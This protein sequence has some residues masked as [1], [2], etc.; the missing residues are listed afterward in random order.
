VRIHGEHLK[1]GA[2]LSEAGKNG[3][4]GTDADEGDDCPMFP[5][6]ELLDLKDVGVGRY[7]GEADVAAATCA[8]EAVAANPSP[9]DDPAAM[10]TA[11][12]STGELAKAAISLTDTE[13]TTAFVPSAEGS[14]FKLDGE[15]KW[16]QVFLSSVSQGLCHA[17]T[18]LSLNRSWCPSGTRQ[19]WNLL[20]VI[21][22]SSN[23]C[24]SSLVR[25]GANNDSSG[26]ASHS[27]SCSIYLPYKRWSLRSPDAHHGAP[28]PPCAK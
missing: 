8:D 27:I 26:C 12:V 9:A 14:E 16:V 25:P 20:F 4:K 24:S 7:T 2:V 19:A 21:V 6:L 18:D 17:Q 23:T 22:F 13:P 10:T 5:N 3:G 15:Y 28:S 1:L 11:A